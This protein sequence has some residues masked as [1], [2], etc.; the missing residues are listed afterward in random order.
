MTESNIRHSGGKNSKLL[1]YKTLRHF[2]SDRD[3]LRLVAYFLMFYS[4][5]SYFSLIPILTRRKYC[6][7]D[8]VLSTDVQTQLPWD[9]IR[10]LV[11]YI[12][13]SSLG[14]SR[15]RRTIA[16]CYKSDRQRFPVLDHV[17]HEV[18]FRNMR[19]NPSL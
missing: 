9:K 14:K 6:S 13:P 4:V 10:A 19:R 5:S 3:V 1:F 15:V 16:C 8:D 2:S 12:L 11:F 7:A 18:H 17:L